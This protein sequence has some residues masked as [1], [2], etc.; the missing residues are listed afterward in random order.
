[1]T[2]WESTPAEGILLPPRNGQSDSALYATNWDAD[3]FTTLSLRLENGREWNNATIPGD[4]RTVAFPEFERER[5][6]G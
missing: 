4:K 1:M 2:D 3:P 6:E 5:C